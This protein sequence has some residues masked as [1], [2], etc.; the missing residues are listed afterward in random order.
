MTKKVYAIEEIRELSKPIMM[1]YKIKKAYVFG[2]YARGE[3]TEKSDIDIIIKKG[4]TVFSLVTLVKFEDDLKKVLK[5]NID[6]VSE[7]TYTHDIKY[8]DSSKRLA[9]KLFYKNIKVDRKK[10]YG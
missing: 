1:K 8:D 5:K 6:V 3:A 4:D 2:S 9:K 10:I 7:D